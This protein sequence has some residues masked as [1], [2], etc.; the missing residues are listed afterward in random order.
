MCIGLNYSNKTIFNLEYKETKLVEDA[1]SGIEI[2]GSNIIKEVKQI[3]TKTNND[4]EF[5]NYFLGNDF[6]N[7]VKNISE[8]DLNNVYIDIS[9]K[10]ILDENGNCKFKVTSIST[11]GKYI[12]KF[13]VSVI[14]RNPF[15]NENNT[16]NINEEQE[17][18][19]LKEEKIDVQNKNIDVNEL[20]VMYDYKE[21]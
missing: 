11:E 8:I 1:L 9:S 16:I 21:I 3:I 5:T 19:E 10:P 12:K 14:I 17:T 20:V 18:L 4:V 15:L 6:I 2:A 13:Q 7:N